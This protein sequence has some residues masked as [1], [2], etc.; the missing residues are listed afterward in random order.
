MS[1]KLSLLVEKKAS[2]FSIS[3]FMPILFKYGDCY[4][5]IFKTWKTPSPK[6][7]ALARRQGLT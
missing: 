2:Y 5:M 4:A 3:I 6:L 7:S 1:M